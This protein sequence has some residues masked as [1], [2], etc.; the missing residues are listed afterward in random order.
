M[1]AGN[2]N[3]TSFVC[4]LQILQFGELNPSLKHVWIQWIMEV[5]N[6]DW[7][8]NNQERQENTHAEWLW[9]HLCRTEAL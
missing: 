9:P 8:Q 2:N 7:E 5:Q 3:K 4:P 1:I 6:M